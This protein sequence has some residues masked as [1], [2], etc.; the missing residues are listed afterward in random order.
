MAVHPRARGGAPLPY[1][2]AMTRWLGPIDTGFKVVNRWLAG[3]ML[4]AGLGSWLSS[5]LTGSMLLLR[6]TGRSSGRPRDVPLGFLVRDG[7]IYVCA[8]MGPATHWYRNLLADPR[9]EVIL[10]DG[11]AVTGLARPVTDPDEW[12]RVF[13]GFVASLGI[14]GRS[15]LGDLHAAAPERLQA[16]RDSLPFIR[17]R[18]T[19]LAAEAGHPTGWGGLLA[20]AAMTWLS[21]TLIRRAVRL[22][23]DRP[24]VHP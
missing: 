10:P 19:G 1:G 20:R 8:G 13:P 3:P 5:P 23:T 12:H 18:V 22:V 17:I 4:R 6:T 14:V 16:I 15:T 21:I 7:A 11:A 2:P 9:V 24:E